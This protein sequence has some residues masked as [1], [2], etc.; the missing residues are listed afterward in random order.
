VLAHQPQGG[1]IE[2]GPGFLGRRRPADRRG[3][4]E[5]AFAQLDPGNLA[6]DQQLALVSG[7]DQ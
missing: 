2:T 7:A 4:G 6:A 1:A 3:E 5:L